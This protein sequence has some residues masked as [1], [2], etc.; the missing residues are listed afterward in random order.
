MLHAISGIKNFKN[1]VVLL[2][3]LVRCSNQPVI[4]ATW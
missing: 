1:E 3:E 2:V 4:A